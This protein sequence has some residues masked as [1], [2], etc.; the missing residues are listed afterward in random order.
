MENV[1][2]DNEN[3]GLNDAPN[4]NGDEHLVEGQAQGGGEEDDILVIPH[5]EEED[6]LVDVLRE[7]NGPN[8]DP[9]SFHFNLKDLY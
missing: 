3:V 1:E 8:E 2:G 5:L 7:W 4:S 9:M 6:V